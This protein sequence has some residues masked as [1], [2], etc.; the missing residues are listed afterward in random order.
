MPSLPS[1]ESRFF[2]RPASLYTAQQCIT[3]AASGAGIGMVRPRLVDSKLT[4]QVTTRRRPCSPP[5]LRIYMCIYY[6][7]IYI[8]TPPTFP[9]PGLLRARTRIRYV[10]SSRDTKARLTFIFMYLRLAKLQ[11]KFCRCSARLAEWGP[12]CTRPRVAR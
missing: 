8:H 9:V 5:P 12:R 10:W 1:L 2:N 6:I 4:N 3:I 7:Y 11:T